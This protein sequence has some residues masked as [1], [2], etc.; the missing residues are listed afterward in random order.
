MSIS[1]VL[2]FVVGYLAIAFEHPFRIN[3][4]ATALFLG[5]SVW[6]IY[7]IGAQQL[8]A[9]VPGWFMDKAGSEAAFELGRSW[10]VEGQLLHLTG[11]TAGL[12][13]FLLGA[14]T[15][16][17][18]VDVH[19]GFSLV[20][21]R[22][23]TTSNAKLL[24]I[25]GWLAFFM[26]SVLDNLTTTIVMVSLLRKIVRDAERRR[27]FVGL[28]VI[29]ANAGGAWT[30]IGDVTTTML[31]MRD[32]FSPWQVMSELFLPSVMCLLVPLLVLT[33]FIRGHVDRDNEKESLPPR[34]VPP[35]Q[36]RL[37]LALGVVGLLS[38]PLF[39]TLT[40][41][42]PFMGML[43]SLSVIWVISEVINHKVDDETRSS[44]G[45]AAVLKRIDLPSILFFLGILL[46]VGALGASGML[47]T[48]AKH[49]DEV[50]GNQTAIAV[51]IGLVSAVVDNVPL[52]AAGIDMYSFERGHP[53]WLLL[54]YTAGTGGSCLIIGSAA[55]VAAMGLERID[56][57]WYLKRIAPLALL[58][59]FAGVA[60]YLVF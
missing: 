20:T 53:F 58:G 31:W 9:D 22:V 34:S 45:V 23:R 43:F 49:L 5:V 38:V 17:E 24:W 44:T 11:E 55:G 50:V 56:F 10:R 25:V 52:V 7:V 6:V 8:E 48:L 19:E 32:K 40:H 42:P 39:K 15:T 47:T 3:K 13:F 41:L 33:F 18:L 12:L 51:V 1:M 29:A 2:V 37:F 59:Y 46:A 14:M 26:S 27:Y 16:V 57:V 30:P 28:V 36:Q 60:T 21:K 54:A 4:A 35:G